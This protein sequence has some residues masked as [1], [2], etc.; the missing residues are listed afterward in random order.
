VSALLS[1]ISIIIT[2]VLM[3]VIRKGE[4]RRTS[5]TAKKGTQTLT[6]CAWQNREAIDSTTAATGD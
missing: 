3:A 1:V 6:F 5:R 4:R 2:A